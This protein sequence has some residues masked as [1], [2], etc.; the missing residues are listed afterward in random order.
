MKILS[1]EDAQIKIKESFEF[2]VE[3]IKKQMKLEYTRLKEENE[4]YNE[5]VRFIKLWN[6]KIEIL[7]FIL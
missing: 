3:D 5:K 2:Q 7:N 1:F 6:G 4:K